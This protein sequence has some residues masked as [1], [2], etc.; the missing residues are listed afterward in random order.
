MILAPAPSPQL[1]N[2][3]SL[4]Q[5]S[6]TN[7]LF[8]WQLEPEQNRELPDIQQ[9]GIKLTRLRDPVHASEAL[10]SHAG[11]VVLVE[12]PEHL[13][14]SHLTLLEQ[15]IAECRYC[16][17]IALL[18]RAWDQQDKLCGLLTH[19][20]FD[21]HYLPPE[22]QRLR[23]IIGH[24]FGMLE[25]RRH[26]DQLS[27]RVDEVDQLIGDSPSMQRIK[28]RILKVATSQSTV[29]ING[30]SGTGKELV[31]RAIHRHSSR[32]DGPFEAINCA[33]LPPNLIQAELFGHEKGA[34][35]D[36]HQRKAG[37]FETC[38]GGT[39][40]LDEIGDMPPEQQVNLLRVLEQN[41]V[42]RIGGLR[43]IPI[44]VRIVA[45]THINLEEAVQQGRFREDL[46]YRLNVI[47]LDM[48]ALRE[49]NTD[50]EMLARFFFKRFREPGRVGPKGFSQEALEAM[51]NYTW[52]GNVRELI[53]RVQHAVVMA[54]GPLIMPYDLGIERREAQRRHITL[55]SARNEAEI[56][57]IND[58]LHRHQSNI[59][60]TAKELGISRV[61]LY[62]LMEKHGISP[63]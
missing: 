49:R 41:S 17:W 57:A 47:K 51:R 31:A 44:D 2:A 48:P 35:T 3:T 24:A 12:F 33:A 27:Y 4:E 55:E 50:I 61:T 18:P 29:L 13:G 37:R 10:R 16:A 1:F 34:Y 19:A 15:L 30:E 20:F 62:R 8:Y 28:N 52:P 60:E 42:R 36:A 45:A 23:I 54:E 5:I 7:A 11:A 9:L 38:N 22:Y 53:N 43:D 25:L 46:F 63:R 21:Y 14:N 32:H 40:F 58:A 26:V 56:H 6:N 39:L 59:S